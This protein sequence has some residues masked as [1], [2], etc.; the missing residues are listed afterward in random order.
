MDVPH[1]AEGFDRL[2]S[3]HGYIEF[4][5]LTMQNVPSGIPHENGQL[6]LS[7]LKHIATPRF[8]FPDKPQ[9]PSDTEIMAKYTGLPFTWDENTSISIGYLGELYIDF[10]YWGGLV[11]V[12]VF[13]WLVGFVYR[14]LRDY[15]ASPALITAGFCLM[16]A[17]PIAYFGTAYVKLIGS[18]AFSSAIAITVQ[19]YGL[20]IVLPILLRQPVRRSPRSRPTPPPRLR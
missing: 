15:A 17:L 20:P 5:G 12:A 9:L 14:S 10:K 16:A 2:V 19:R 13:G 1:V 3:R 11:A 6:T 18:F 8:L 4:L 7:V